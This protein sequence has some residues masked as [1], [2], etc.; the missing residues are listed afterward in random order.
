MSKFIGR[1]DEL[2]KLIEISQKKT[3]SFILVKGRRRIGKS[4][5]IEEYGKSFDRFYTFIGLAPVE[6][7]HA[8]H[9]LEEFNRQISQQFR[10]PQAN[11]DDWSN[12]LWAVAEN[13]KQGKTLLFFDEISWIGSED[14]TFL[15]KIKN[16]WDLYL[17]KNDQLVFVV[18]GSASAWI[19]KNILSHTGFVGRI[20][21]TLTLKE[22]S[23]N[24]CNYFWPKNISFYEK[25]KVLFMTGGIPKYLEEISPKLSAEENIKNLCFL[26][27]APL[28]EEF[29]HIFSNL[30]LR[31]SVF[32]KKIVETL[33]SGPKGRIE[34]CEAL[35]IEPG[36]R[37]SQYLF[38][39]ELAGFIKRDHSWSILTAIDSKLSK[40]RLCDNYLRFY[41]KY[42][43]KN[44]S[45]IDNDQ[46]CFT[47]LTSLPEWSEMMG[48]QLENLVLSNRSLI[49]K[50]LHI[51]PDEVVCDNPFFQHKTKSQVGCQIDYLIQT[52][53]RTLYVCEIK[54]SKNKIDA[55]II[56]EVQKKIEAL[57]YPKGFSCRPVLIHANDVTDEVVDYFAGIVNVATLLEN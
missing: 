5:L 15:S 1:Q 11:Y 50:A 26:R 39:L 56:T 41:L 34:I 49:I 29:K 32:Y 43:D 45:K 38:E 36:G 7:L 31:D 24:D 21:Y 54:F 18:C 20:S 35:K 51:N 4:R 17:K 19:E 22:L 46:F 44:V 13:V 12:A 53:Y 30:F 8:K 23:L 48:Y 10:L 3:A 33:V 9:Q 55:S 25:L 16:F 57:T 6:G 52:T 42:I 47:S 27:G 14:P 40:Y 2:K 37:I 28:I